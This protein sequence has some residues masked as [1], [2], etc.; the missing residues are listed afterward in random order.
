MTKLETLY[1]VT[2]GLKALGR[3]I[4]DDL[5]NELK[6]EERKYIDEV[7]IPAIREHINP[8][9]TKLDCNLAM[10]LSYMDR[11][12]P[13]I[14]VIRHTNEEPSTEG[15][16]DEE[17]TK[18]EDANDNKMNTDSYLQVNKTGTYLV[19]DSSDNNTAKQPGTLLI[20]REHHKFFIAFT[21]TAKALVITIDNVM[22]K[23]HNKKY[24]IDGFDGSEIVCF[25]LC[26]IDDLLRII[27]IDN[28]GNEW[29]KVVEASFLVSD[30][31]RKTPLLPPG[32]NLKIVEVVPNEEKERVKGMILNGTTQPGYLS[33][34]VIES[35]QAEKIAWL[36]S[37]RKEV[38]ISN[39]LREME[40]KDFYVLF[41][42]GW[43]CV[44][45][46]ASQTMVKAINEML[47][48]TS[49]EKLASVGIIID[50]K[51]MLSPRFLADDDESRFHKLS[52]GWWV[53]TH[54]N[55]KTKKDKLE[56]LAKRCNIKLSVH[57]AMKKK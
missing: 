18:E 10:M 48:Y 4:D 47:K 22:S 30:I 51:P 9:I 39:S 8:L 28:K 56:L 36:K 15:K 27:S 17:I 32:F 33:K 57:L 6:S 42:N 38:V 2:N 49:I 46:D 20:N 1:N 24:T 54:M 25:A 13:V 37:P 7:I 41:D 16:D 44:G 50:R 34:G 40:T 21:K 43:Q 11:E 29:K 19:F 23:P 35:P 45:A 31:Y 52:N 53:N 12:E 3:S 5:L 26:D 55:N 14:E